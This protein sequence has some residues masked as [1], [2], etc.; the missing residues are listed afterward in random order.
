MACRLLVRALTVGVVL[1]LFSTPGA[2]LVDA[3]AATSSSMT[4][5]VRFKPCS[6]LKRVRCG[7]V[8]VPLDY[9]RSTPGDLRL[10]VTKRPTMGRSRGTILLLAG[11]PG[12]ASA[13]TFDL[14]SD[15][16]ISLFPGFTVAAYDNRGTGG[17]GLLACPGAKTAASC[18]RGIG[19]SRVFYGT[20]ENTEDIES[21][22][23]ALG[24]DRIA[25]FGLSYGTKQA[26]AYAAAH[27]EHVDRLLLDSTVLP[28]GPDPLGLA[29]LRAIPAALDSIC[30]GGACATVSGDPA[31][32]FAKLANR[33]EAEPL[34]AKAPVYTTNRTPTLRRVRV[35]GLGLLSLATASDLNTGIAI[36]LPAAV[37]AALVG[38]TGLLERTAALVS[39]QD[40]SA[41]N[42]AVF[43]ATTCNDGPFPWHPETPTADRRTALA[44][45]VAVLPR[46]SLGDFGSW[47]AVASAIECL[48]WPSPTGVESPGTG[49][50]PNVP[51]LV[52]AGDRDVR[53]PLAAGAAAAARF[54]QGRLL[55]VPGIGHT[56]VA[57]SACVDNAI[58]TWIEGKAPPAR[59]P[60]VPLTLEPIGIPPRAVD[61]APPRGP[62]GGLVGRTLGATV[63][64]LRGAEAAWLTSYPEGWVVGLEAGLLAG[65][66]LSGFRFS[67]YSDVPGLAVSGRLAF[68]VSKMGTLVPGS[69]R[70]IVQVGGSRA[71]GGFLQVR[72]RRIFGV[73]GGRRV[74][75]SF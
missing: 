31:S 20:R 25:L 53:T 65:E 37:R 22:R 27:P 58:R 15:L 55:V 48:D 4:A 44:N 12:E 50:L 1:L 47:A 16:W 62:V 10:F 71:A 70:G 32:D 21:V 52:L 7:Y 38:R 36:A 67:A 19:P 42:N 39:K 2:V 11:G 24:V 18:A 69:E 29:S 46:G 68:S 59:C 23:R 3:S 60:R 5:A 66:D 13:Q 49:S 61:D 57:S 35:D 8:S 73:L 56:V 30:H 51:V 17:S 40:T 64:T 54:P 74:S 45:A 72:N 75:T 26:L 34:V 9:S 6:S 41:V 28:D 33:L 14:N 43:L 63:A